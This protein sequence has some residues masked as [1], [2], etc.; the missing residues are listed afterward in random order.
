[1]MN[2]EKLVTVPWKA[3]KP[4]STAPARVY[5]ALLVLFGL[6][7]V[8]HLN[9]AVL[10]RVQSLLHVGK[11]AIVAPDH[12]HMEG[13]VVVDEAEYLEDVLNLGLCVS[14]SVPTSVVGS[15]LHVPVE[16]AYL[17]PS[18]IYEWAGT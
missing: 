9:V 8:E 4:T 6:V 12:S 14:F 17:R 3:T 10:G 16:H 13:G 15:K 11:L 1:M 2:V 5:W 7:P 18:F